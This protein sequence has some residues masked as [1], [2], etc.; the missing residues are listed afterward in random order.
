[1]GTTVT[2]ITE[3]KSPKQSSPTRQGKPSSPLPLC[4]SCIVIPSPCTRCSYTFVIATTCSDQVRPTSSPNSIVCC[5]TQHHHHLHQSPLASPS[6][7]LSSS[8]LSS[9]LAIDIGPY[10][11]QLPLPL[12]LPS[13]SLTSCRRPSTYTSSASNRFH[14]QCQDR[15]SYQVGHCV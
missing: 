5:P 4:G 11:L 10:P 14:R 3:S 12:P 7:S 13:P 9:S 15:L 8:S 2:N 6:P 1:M